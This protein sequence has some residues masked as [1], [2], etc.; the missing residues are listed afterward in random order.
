MTSSHPHTCHSEMCRRRAHSS[1]PSLPGCLD[2][3]SASIICHHGGSGA[4]L[5]YSEGRSSR[6]VASARSI[7]SWEKAISQKRLRRPGPARRTVYQILPFEYRACGD[8]WTDWARPRRHLREEE[9]RGRHSNGPDSQRHRRDGLD[10]EGIGG[11]SEL[12]SAR[13]LLPSLDRSALPRHS[14]P[15]AASIVV[16]R[17]A[18]NRKS[19]ELPSHTDSPSIDRPCPS[20]QV[21]LPAIR[22]VVAGM[23][24]LASNSASSGIEWDATALLLSI[25]SFRSVREGSPSLSVP[26]PSSSRYYQQGWEW[27]R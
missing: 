18:S 23:D 7:F 14:A 10:R 16:L 9:L 19:C 5:L 2:K 1:R 8:R 25:T 11:L 20:L 4:H 27:Y 26:P 22:H 24:G 6:T 21:R 17:R 12:S 15:R 3:I 13:T